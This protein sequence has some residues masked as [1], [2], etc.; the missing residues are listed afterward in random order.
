[1]EFKHT[2][3]DNGLT[4][5]AEVNPAAASMAAG[6]FIRTG[7]RDETPEVAG[8][9]HFLEHMVFK[10]T[11]R[12]SA[13]DVN[14]EFDEMGAQYNAFTSEENTVYFAAVLPDFQAR[15]MDL[16]ADILRP[17]LRG[18]D[19]DVEKQI[20]I[21]EIARYQDQPA[22]LVYEKLMAAHFAGHALGRGVL[23]TTESVG[24]LKRSDMKAYFDR[25]YSPGNV[26]LVAVGNLDFDAFENQ[27]AEHCSHWTPCRAGRC[28][29]PA[30][31]AGTTN[32]VL[33]KKLA[34]EH[35]GLMSAA[36]SGQDDERY[37]SQLLATIVG[38]TNGSRLFYAL[39]DPA[40]ADEAHMNYEPLDNAG[41]FF[42]FLST[43]P[44]RAAEA[45]RIVRRELRKFAEEGPGDAELLA[46]KNKIA[47]G[48]TLRGELP[49]GRLTAVGF[50]WVYRGEY[51]PLAEQIETLFAVTAEDVLRVARGHD[52]AATTLLSLGPV[53]AL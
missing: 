24:A 35:I 38:D 51:M 50:D 14:R 5:I 11:E 30:T 48:A 27:A 7:S 20:I 37:A 46:A 25:R 44:D 23:G 19:F 43:D 8:V 33:D 40:I 39:V 47:S 16:L 42:T 1:M 9:S 31:P 49:M 17:A 4:V 52:L 36:P 34:R 29:R 26:T 32:I 22:Y 15:A 2:Q 53:E 18:E 45:V 28:P 10:G 41:A 12:R 13:F 3:L 21:D 6:F